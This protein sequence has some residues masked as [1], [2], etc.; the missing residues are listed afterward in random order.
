M[1][2]V[3]EISRVAASIR[4]RVNNEREAAIEEAVKLVRDG[5]ANGTVTLSETE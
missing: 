2:H 3:E 1:Q 4:T 5:I